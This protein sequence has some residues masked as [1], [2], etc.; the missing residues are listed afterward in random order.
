MNRLARCS[1]PNNWRIPAHNK[2]MFATKGFRGTP[3]FSVGSWSFGSARCMVID[4]FFPRVHLRQWSEAVAAEFLWNI[5]VLETFPVKMSNTLQG[6][7]QSRKVIYACVSANRT[8]YVLLKTCNTRKVCLGIVNVLVSL[9]CFF[10]DVGL[11]TIERV[12]NTYCFHQSNPIPADVN[13]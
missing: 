8:H 1:K 6:I 10:R 3:Q 12:Q 9:I 13:H 4:R 7:H 2:K 5:V 11:L